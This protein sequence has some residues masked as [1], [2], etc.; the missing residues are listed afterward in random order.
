MNDHDAG[1]Y[2]DVTRA[3][4]VVKLARVHLADLATRARTH[5]PACKA[6]DF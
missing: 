1:E 6:N 3:A 2:L 5:R 4:S